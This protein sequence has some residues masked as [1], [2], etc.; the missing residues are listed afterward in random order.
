MKVS[1][2]LSLRSPSIPSYLNITLHQ[3]SSLPPTLLAHLYSPV[4]LP[5]TAKAT[6]LVDQMTRLLNQPQHLSQPPTPIVQH[7]L[8]SLLLLEIHH[9]R[10]SIDSGVDGSFDDEFGEDGFGSS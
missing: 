2:V 7:L 1:S 4:R 6:H 3:P 5:E 10:W 9:S 8:A